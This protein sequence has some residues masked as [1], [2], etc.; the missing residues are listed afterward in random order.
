M[1]IYSVF[2]GL[3]PAIWC[4]LADSIGRRPIYIVCFAIYIGSNIGLA[5]ATDY[6]MLLG[7][8]I[9]QAAGAASTV[10]LGSGVVTDFTVQRERG[11]YI[12]IYSGVSLIGNTFGPVIGGLLSASL[13]WR[14]VFWFLCISAG[15]MIVIIIIAF[16]ET[17][18]FLALNGSLIPSNFIN[19]SPYIYI[20]KRIKGVPNKTV[21]DIQPLQRHPLRLTACLRLFK[22]HDVDL[23]LIP[24]SLTYTAWYM[25]LTAQSTLLTSEYG[26]TTT[27]TGLSFLASGGGCIIGSF[28]SGRAM[29]WYYKKCYSKYLQDR[30]R[31][32][33]SMRFNIPQARLGL[34]IY[35][36]IGFVA[37]CILFGWSIQYRVHYIVP[38]LATSIA[39]LES[40]FIVNLV[41][42]L[43]VDL[44]P[45]DSA[46]ATAAVNLT[47]CLTC[48]VGLAVL[49]RMITSLGCGGA[50]TLM[51]GICVVSMVCIYIELKNGL[52]FIALRVKDYP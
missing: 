24:A 31:T 28:G 37:S 43:L 11:Q 9:L 34:A 44:F 12:G 23:V 36:A 10:A 20:R 35:Q 51:G 5:L 19:K 13:G 40:T 50:F 15:V 18:R 6:S 52:K 29:G 47:R 42:T 4:A 39:A 45:D 25:M 48:A 46:S 26:F 3:S 27:Q 21:R 1:T 2:Q 16:P 22:F 38:I 14:S 32:S 8:R 41:T 33:E 7:L 49:D 17:N 30:E